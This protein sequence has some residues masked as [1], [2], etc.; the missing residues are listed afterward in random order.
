MK[1]AVV[2]LIAGG[3]FGAG[4]AFSGMVDPMRV[5]AFLDIFGQWD[6]TLAF[7]MS[8]ALIP[9][10]VAWLI[11]RRLAKPLADAGFNI[12]GTSKLD[13]RLAAGAVLFG[14][15]WGLSGL[16]PGPAVADLALNP[17]PAFIFVIAM[18]AGMAAE[19]FVIK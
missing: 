13:G 19:R 15:G 10:I 3:L 18:A 14:I 5:Q 8:G 17:L 7:V 16:C 1:Q 4:L 11:Q 6:P 12:P 2:A 9:M